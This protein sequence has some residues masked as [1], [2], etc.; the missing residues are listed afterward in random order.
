MHTEGP[1]ILHF[2]TYKNLASLQNNTHWFI[3]GTFGVTPLL[4]MQVYTIHALINNKV[5]PCIYSFLPNKIKITYTLVQEALKILN[6]K[7]A[8][9][10]ILVDF[11]KAMHKIVETV[12]PE[13]EIKGFFFHL[14]QSIYRKI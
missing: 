2:G 13:T 14:F 11:E 5:T 4:F 1:S 10:A 7:L 8:P 6:N 12:F 3:D 9:D